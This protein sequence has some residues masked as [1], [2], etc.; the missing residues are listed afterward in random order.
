MNPLS[1]TGDNSNPAVLAETSKGQ[2]LVLLNVNPTDHLSTIIDLYR[3]EFSL[4]SDLSAA[5]S[6]FREMFA[7]YPGSTSYAFLVQLEDIP[8]FEIDLHHASLQLPYFSDFTP[9]EEDYFISVMPGNFSH[10]EFSVYVSGLKLCLD[11]FFGFPAAKRILAVV[12]AG[13]YLEKRTQLFA[14]AGL[15]LLRERTTSGE[16]DLYVIDRPTNR[17]AV[18]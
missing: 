15:H 2:S 9:T 6:G 3:K 10:A 5:I 13:P 11:Y 12:F 14:D 18:E 8:L 17:T 16:P 4:T 1:H 7:S